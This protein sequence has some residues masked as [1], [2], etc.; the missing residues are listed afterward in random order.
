MK[1]YN[2]TQLYP[3]KGFERHVFH[4]DLFAHYLRWSHVLKECKQKGVE[5]ILDVGCADGNL[6]MTLYV[7]RV[8]PQSYLGVDIRQK[9]IQHAQAKF[10]RLPGVEF[11]QQDI[12]TT[13]LPKRGYTM[14]ACFEVLEHV[15]KKNVPLVLDNIKQAMDGTT[16]L[17][18]STPCYDEKVGAA[19]NHTIHG[20]PQELTFSETKELLSSRF[21]I[22]NYWG[23]FA[24]QKD[25]I[26]SMDEHTKALFDFMRGYYDANVLSVLFAPAFPMQSRNVLWEMM[27]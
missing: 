24:S 9:T 3:D 18:I 21:R 6:L 2:T 16:R 14:I 25:I 22:V 1:E 13:P 26:S 15:Q 4:R 17:F 27:R 19:E 12:V 5:R 8:L 11:M 20:A 10:S 23:T 7:N